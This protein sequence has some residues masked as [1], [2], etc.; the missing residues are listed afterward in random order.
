MSTN[1]NS[2]LRSP[3]V[4][5]LPQRLELATDIEQLKQFISTWVEESDSEVRD[6]VRWQ[7]LSTPKYFRPVT[8]FACHWAMKD[9]PVPLAVF[10]SAVALELIHNVSLIIDDILDH[11]RYRRG[12]PSLHCRYGMLPALM[13]AGYLT[14]AALKLT[15][16]DAYSIG[17][18]TELLQR[19]GIAECAQWRLRRQPLGVEDWRMIACEDTGSMFETCAQLGTRDDRLRK[20][21]QTLGIL[22]HGCDDVADVRGTEAL[23][24]S[25]QEDMRDGIL[26]LPAALAIR[27]P[28]VAVLF[29]TKAAEGKRTLIDRFI[30]VLPEAEDYLDRVAGEAEGE[31]KQNAL[32]Q[33]R[34]ITLIGYTRALSKS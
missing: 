13:V 1:P 20:F 28:H 11:S 31:V 5:D 8:V 22:Y 9:H 2:P 6:M 32:F 18:L 7:L 33:E 14:A 24:G 30:A 15:A 4:W 25:G 3:A 21:G 19:L 10:R 17:L 23:G 26:T 12:K 34:L 27:N 16:E 29:R